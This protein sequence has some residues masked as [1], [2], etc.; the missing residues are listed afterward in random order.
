MNRKEFFEKYG[1]D[2]GGPDEAEYGP[3]HR[4]YEY[5]SKEAPF[6]RIEFLE[7]YIA[8]LKSELKDKEHVYNDDF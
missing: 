2:R 5:T 4:G 8:A 6:Q 1:F 7:R 3:W